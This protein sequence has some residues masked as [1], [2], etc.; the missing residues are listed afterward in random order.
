MKPLQ[1]ERG[2]NGGGG[3]RVRRDVRRRRR[4]SWFGKEYINTVTKEGRW[5][6][7]R[8]V[9]PL[10]AAVMRERQGYPANQQISDDHTSFITQR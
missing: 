8:H 6:T 5:E 3:E 2:M 4:R 9:Y 1:E 7:G 10:A